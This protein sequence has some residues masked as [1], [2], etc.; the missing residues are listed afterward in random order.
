[1]TANNDR[2]R[3]EIDASD[4]TNLVANHSGQG[5]STTGWQGD[6]GVTLSTATNPTRSGET[7][8]GAY[9]GGKTIKANFGASADLYA[10]VRSPAFNVSPGQFIGVEVSFA[11]SNPLA[12]TTQMQRYLMLNWYNSGGTKVGYS[13]LELAHLVTSDPSPWTMQIA[14]SGYRGKTVPPG[15]VTARV[16]LTFQDNSVSSGFLGKIQRDIYLSKLM[17][18]QDPDWSVVGDI[19]F[20]DGTAWQNV[21]GSAL[22][23]DVER[24]GDLRGVVDDL[25]AGRLTATL[26]DSTV[27]PAQNPRMRPG[28]LIRLTTLDSTAVWRPLFT[29]RVDQLDV[30][31]ADKRNP[32][33]KPRVTLTAVDAVAEARNTAQPFNFDGTLGQ[34]VRAIMQASTLPFVTDAG[35]M[36]TTKVTSDEQAKVWDQL[37]L[38]RNSF[39]NATLWVDQ[40]GVVQC[41]TIPPSGSPAFTLNNQP[42][43]NLRNLLKTPA[44]T[45]VLAGD[46]PDPSF[47]ASA[48]ADVYCAA[49][50]SYAQSTDWAEQ[51]SKSL[52]ISK[53]NTNSSYI[54]ICDFAAKKNGFGQRLEQGADV[55]A[56]DWL[57][58]R[59]AVKAVVPM[60]GR[61]YGY[62][63][64]DQ[65][66][67]GDFGTILQ[68]GSVG[69]DITLAAGQVQVITQAFKVTDD[70]RVNWAKMELQFGSTSPTTGFGV[71]GPIFY[72]DGLAL[73]NL[74]PDPVMAA[75]SLPFFAESGTYEPPGFSYTDI[76]VNFGAGVLVNELMFN[77][78]NSN[79]VDG[80]KQY[81]PYIAAAS[82]SAWG[83]STDEVDIIDGT[84]STL[85]THYLSRFSTPSIFPR[86]VEYKRDSANDA[87]VFVDLY[88]EVRAIYSPAGVDKVV[89]VVGVS[90]K[91]TPDA[92]KISLRLRPQ[93]STATTVD[94]P[95]AG[96]DTGPVDVFGP[97]GRANEIGNAVDLDSLTA[98][99]VYAQSSNT[100]AAAGTNYPVPQAGWLEV[101]ANYDQS[102]VW[103]RYTVYNG[104]SFAGQ[105]YSR[106]YYSGAWSAWR[107]VG[108]NDTLP[109]GGRSGS[110]TQSIPNASITKVTLLTVDQGAQG[111]VT[112]NGTNSEFTVTKPGIYMVHGRVA[113]TVNATGLRLIYL[114]VNGSAINL[115]SNN[116]SVG[117]AQTLTTPM[118][119]AS[120]DKITLTCYQTSTGNL[121]LIN[122]AGTCGLSLAYLGA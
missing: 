61:V 105:T 109:F 117:S 85:A 82:R 16:A 120:G 89:T 99:G 51:G 39:A 62:S 19:P 64:R 43:K 27:D 74:G 50:I 13:V 77:R 87:G 17:V 52:L 56:G 44:R 53:T 40:S 31:Y 24:G 93:D 7:L 60:K 35:A 29:G 104:G 81:G 111:G 84:P 90:H 78:R 26:L 100:E 91:I 48:D 73:Y 41:R 49:G 83:S 76:D 6:T 21:L 18:V 70:S 116:A 75:A 92:W 47:E 107:A 88:D 23:V 106:T 58:F 55:K 34:K 12:A 98:P 11:D 122:N 36:S 46:F 37:L 94:V 101:A 20:A 14:R 80:Q 72:V 45:P 63:E 67:P 4:V 65:E 30:S 38:A 54:T 110:G 8:L 1:M 97:P 66:Y 57:Y 96:A 114:N 108:A 33:A 10:E 59:A 71:S 42:A 119:L 103:Q 9:T 69:A 5:G 22:N 25:E 15:A 2:V 79:E 112:W 32:A 68:N 3:L 121:N 102:M 95:A 113:W 28:R 118:L 115:I 86:R